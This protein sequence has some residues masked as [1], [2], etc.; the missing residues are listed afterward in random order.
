MKK[1]LALIFA[2]SFG[3]AHAQFATVAIQSNANLIGFTVGNVATNTTAFAAPG[4][5]GANQNFA[6]YS[7][8]AGIFKNMFIRAASAPGAG[9]TTTYTLYVGTIAAMTSTSVTCTLS[10]AAATTCSDTTNTAPIAAGQAWAIQVATSSGGTATAQ[11]IMGIE[12]DAQ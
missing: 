9:Q 10:G 3:C 11:Q 4:T 6:A 8:R 2:L 1:L 5:V 12:L 7:P